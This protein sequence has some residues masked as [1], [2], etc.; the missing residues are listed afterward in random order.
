[1]ISRLLVALFCFIP[2]VAVCA[3]EGDPYPHPEIPHGNFPAL[4][5]CPDDSTSFRHITCWVGQRFL[6]LPSSDGEHDYYSLKG[7]SESLGYKE[8]VGRIA[9]ITDVRYANPF[10][11]ITMKMEDDGRLYTAEKLNSD[12]TGED[13]DVSGLALASDIDYIRNRYK[14]KMVWLKK[15]IVTRYNYDTEQFEA[16]EYSGAIKAR[17]TDVIPGWYEWAPVRVLF[18]AEDGEEWFEDVAV[19][20]TNTSQILR[21][22]GSSFDQIFSMTPVTPKKAMK[23]VR[24]KKK[25]K[26]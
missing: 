2:A 14:G 4:E 17:I 15:S 9:I 19:S 23:T 24:K 11:Y 25:K 7:E 12:G 6:L 22:T 13:V 20:R 1:M 3:A 16:K 5:P 8:G 10:W 21:T 18:Q 26:R